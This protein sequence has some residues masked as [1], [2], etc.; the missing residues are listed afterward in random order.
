MA[1]PILIREIG[2]PEPTSLSDADLAALRRSKHVTVEP[3]GAGQWKVKPAKALVGSLRIEHL[4]VHVRPKL[5]IR[6]VLFLMGYTA[7]KQS[8]IAWQDTTVG[9]DKA[10]GL[11]PAFAHMVWRAAERALAE[12]P[13]QGYRSADAS[14][15]VLR[16]RIRET[17]QLYQGH[18]MGIPLQ[19][20]Y[21][22]LTTDI[23]E[24]QILRTALG[25]MLTTPGLDAESMLRIHRL[26]RRLHDVTPIPP[27]QPT[28][29]CLENRLNTRYHDALRLAELVLRNRSA[30]Q[31]EGTIAA[32]GFLVNMPYLFEDFVRHAVG[33]A[34]CEIGGGRY[35]HQQPTWYLDTTRDL[36]LKPDLVWE[37]DGRPIAVADAKY[38]TERSS[39]GGSRDAIFQMLAYCAAK[40]LR[41]GHLIYARGHAE[42]TRYPI[43]A[44]GIE[45][46]CH[47]LDLDQDPAGL[48]RGVR[49]L[50][51]SIAAESPDQS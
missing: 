38:M 12:G 44:A 51:E 30:E 6:R 5:P 42:P 26:L 36:E 33:R 37:R 3:D 48:L 21:D 23:P 25:R 28:P 19:V 32:N 18:A 39:L 27:G 2:N 31:G 11:V 47:S 34:L 14:S 8:R 45:I 41:H 1:T 10:D 29:Q 50:A 16:G 4:E 49:T 43:A 46:V 40:G 13:L 24:N 22:D 20:R 17:A 15:T 35:L 7:S 9:L